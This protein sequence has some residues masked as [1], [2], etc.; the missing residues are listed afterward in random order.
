MLGNLQDKIVSLLNNNTVKITT[1]QLEKRKEI[2]YTSPSPGIYDQQWFWDSCLH[3]LVW[4]KLGEKERAFQELESLIIGKRNKEYFPH[5]I[6]W[7]KK[8]D[9]YWRLFDSL[10]PTETSSEI[11]QPPIIGV[12]LKNL[13]SSSINKDRLEQVI[14]S[15]YTHYNYITEIRDPEDMG[16]ITIV[17]PWESGLDSSPCFDLG[18]ESSYFLRLRLWQR[19]RNLLKEFKTLNWE[20][21]LMAQKSSFKVK[22]V[23]TNS[24]LAWG[25]DSFADV[26]EYF[27]RQDEAFVFRE[28]VD[29][30]WHSLL[31]YCW[32][33]EEGLF[34]SLNMKNGNHS[35]I[36]V[37]TISS[38]LPLLLDI[39]S[40]IRD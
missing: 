10:Y 21:E 40:D 30:I 39:P 24:L 34:Y 33:E 29:R 38:L 1:N 35:Q 14:D 22:C 16:L 31:S 15:T 12:A 18:L 4:L 28:K 11:I 26:L 6:F 37:N 9:I 23:L 13:V 19:M 20:Q 32:N 7:K 5:M 27:N 8:K 36:T 25:M 17:H 2:I 3:S